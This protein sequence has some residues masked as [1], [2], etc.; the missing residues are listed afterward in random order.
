M[1]EDRS[2][3]AQAKVDRMN[4]ALQHEEPDRIPLGEF[5]WGA[6]L[7]RWRKELGLPEDANIYEHYDLDWIVTVP[8]MD[9]HIRDF[10]IIK[11]TNGEVI[12]RTGFEAIVR[13]RFDAP[14]P[15]AVSWETDTIEKLEAF[16][17]DPPED[18]R[19]F[20]AGGDNHIAG[21]GDGYARNSPPWRDTVLALRDDFAVY[22][23]MIEASE[24]LTRLIG[25]MNY[26]QWVGEYPERFGEQV[27]RAGEFCRKC[28]KAELEAGAGLLD[29]MVIW[30]DVAFCG[31][32]FFSPDYWRQYFKPAV[33]AM[34]EMCHD[35]DLPV[36][37]H[38]CGNVASIL[39]DFMEMGL[40]AYNPLEAKAGLDVVDL[41]RQYGHRLGFCG[42]GNVQLW[43]QGDEEAIRGEVLR[44]LNAAKGGGYIFQSDHSVSSGVSGKTYDYIIKLLREHGQYPLELGDYDEQL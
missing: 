25:Q 9:P 23:S 1:N 24:C 7:S 38:G 10:K 44:K 33:Q 37:Y 5:Y 31:N 32:L 15:E 30:G 18:A 22:G 14:M 11:E 28:C 29:G 20:H 17:Y 21:V 6:F 27:L 19:R 4:A 8:N 26:F 41:R 35:H 43:E 16:D 39:P 36:I 34:I 40:D 3:K 13:K 12:L 42:N 2:T